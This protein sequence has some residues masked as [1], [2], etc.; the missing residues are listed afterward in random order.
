MNVSTH[1][2]RAALCTVLALCLLGCA[3]SPRTDGGARTGPESRAPLALPAD[4][5]AC[6][7]LAFER[8]VAEHFQVERTASSAQIAVLV[9]ALDADPV[10]A[11]RAA[12]LLAHIPD[13]AATAALLERLERRVAGAARA[14]DAGDCT[15]AAALGRRPLES[16]DTSRLAGLVLDG[17]GAHPDFEVRV[18]CARALL[19]HGDL[20]GVPF[21]LAVAR[22]DTPFARERGERLTDSDATAW[23]RWRA[24]SGLEAWLGLPARYDPDMPPAVRDILARELEAAAQMR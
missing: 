23:P 12:I 15:A 9:T 21:L 3:H 18:E 7:P 4:W 8:F 19:D 14:A 1:R 17:P 24:A 5:R 22:H 16:E 2:T 10:L 20:S 13:G 11:T 6:T